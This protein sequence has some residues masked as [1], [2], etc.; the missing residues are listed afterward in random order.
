[1]KIRQKNWQ[2]EQFYFKRAERFLPYDQPVTTFTSKQIGI[3]Y[4]TII[5]SEIDYD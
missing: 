4:A 1:M 3:V 5:Y 2:S